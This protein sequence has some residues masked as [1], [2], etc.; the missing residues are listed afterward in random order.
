MD[1]FFLAA[2]ESGF[3]A[4]NMQFLPYS[5]AV[6]SMDAAT[7]GTRPKFYS[8]KLQDQIEI[9][10]NQIKPMTDSLR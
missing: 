6:Y 10:L 3:F 5:L 4:N 2:Q 1:S 8:T 9:N 7:K